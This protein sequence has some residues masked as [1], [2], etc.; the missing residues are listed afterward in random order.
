MKLAKTFALF[1]ATTVAALTL[2]ASPTACTGIYLDNEAPTIT[3]TNLMP[4]TRE[5]CFSEFAVLHSGIARS[6]LWSAEHLF[7][8]QLNIKV[9]RTED[10]HAEERLPA[11]ERAELRDFAHSGYDRGHLANAR[12]RHTDQGEHESFSLCNMIMQDHDNNTKLFS[13]LEEATRQLAKREGE[14]YVI[15]GPLFIGSNIKRVNGRVMVPTKIYKAIY[16][17]STKQGA[18]YL[19]DNAPGN[20]YQVVSIAQIEQLAGINLFPKM[21]AAA[22]AQPMRLPAPKMHGGGNNNDYQSSNQHSN[23]KND[24]E[25]TI[26]NEVER[27]VSHFWKGY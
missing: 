17:P 25:R 16:D 23:Y 5:L 10:F 11:D 12:D 26:S 27:K 1:L 8:Q 3:N 7:G 22:K 21:S 13:G 15:S 14:L 20:D 2:Q 6:P 18:A 4:K 24:Y 9:S 19:M